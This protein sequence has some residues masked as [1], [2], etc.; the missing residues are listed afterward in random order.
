MILMLAGLGLILEDY[1]ASLEAGMGI[2]SEND[3][4][5]GRKVSEMIRV[6]RRL[7]GIRCCWFVMGRL[8]LR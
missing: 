8:R 6:S 7:D 2:Y 1:V 3:R 5:S 4:A